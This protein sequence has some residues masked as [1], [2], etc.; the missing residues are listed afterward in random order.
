MANLV[1]L[2][3]FDGPVYVDTRELDSGITN[4]KAYSSDGSWFPDARVPR[5]KL[6]ATRDLAEQNYNRILVDLCNRS[7]RHTDRIPFGL[8]MIGSMRN[9][10]PFRALH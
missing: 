3:T 8:G 7:R 4:L 10:S 6:F 5:D 9:E 2:Y 1:E